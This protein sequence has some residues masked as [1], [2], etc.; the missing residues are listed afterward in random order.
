MNYVEKVAQGALLIDVRGEEEYSLGHFEGSIN[1]PHL[2][3]AETDLPEDKEQELLVYCKMGPR[4]EIAKAILNH[5][6][7]HRVYY[8]GGLEDVSDLGFT[9]R[10]NY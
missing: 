3:L 4:A 2:D 1:I 9:F 7:Y 8:L 6:G 5:R 10:G